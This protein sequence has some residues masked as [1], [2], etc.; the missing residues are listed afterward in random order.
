MH[1]HTQA[2]ARVHTRVGD[3]EMVRWCGAPVLHARTHTPSAFHARVPFLRWC[4][5][6]LFGGSDS[7]PCDAI[8]SQQP[9][10]LFLPALGSL[11]APTYATFARARALSLSPLSLLSLSS[12]ST[13]SSLLAATR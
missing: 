5:V 10:P 12:L 8:S 9:A 6:A 1:A 4:G 11:C 2:R 7:L 13:L 3:G